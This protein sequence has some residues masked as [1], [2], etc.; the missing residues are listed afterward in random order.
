[1]N[2]GAR[3]LPKFFKGWKPMYIGLIQ[4]FSPTRYQIL[5]AG[6]NTW[7]QYN[8]SDTSFFTDEERAWVADEF[9]QL[10]PGLRF[11]RHNV[12]WQQDKKVDRY[13]DTQCVCGQSRHYRV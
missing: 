8:T 10:R 11:K 5:P 2:V 9:K 1:M 4:Y 6:S 13:A 3:K 7:L 12:I